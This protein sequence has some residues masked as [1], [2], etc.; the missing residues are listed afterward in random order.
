MCH[1]FGP[2]GF[3]IQP[4]NPISPPPGTQLQASSAAAPLAEQPALLPASQALLSEMMEQLGA[5]AAANANKL[6]GTVLEEL[7]AAHGAH[8]TTDGRI[9]VAEQAAPMDISIM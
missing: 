3:N 9:V 8:I 6:H 1:R 2:A 7:L 5:A 4:H